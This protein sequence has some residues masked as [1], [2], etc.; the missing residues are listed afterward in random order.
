MKHEITETDDISTIRLEGKLIGSD[1]ATRV[2]ND[3]DRLLTEGKRKF[4]L[5]LADLEWMDSTGLG[6]FITFLTRVKQAGGKLVLVNPKKVESLLVVTRLISI[7]DIY[8][9]VEAAKEGLSKGQSGAPGA[10][11]G[12]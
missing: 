10:T 9:T 8:Q 2:T 4:I 12:M 5:E 7:F 6:V 3:L 11:A 1:A